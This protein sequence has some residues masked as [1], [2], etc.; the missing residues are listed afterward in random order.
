[1]P[2]LALPKNQGF[3]PKNQAITRAA[4]RAAGDRSHGATRFLEPALGRA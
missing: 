2:T 1:M 3:Q 4:E